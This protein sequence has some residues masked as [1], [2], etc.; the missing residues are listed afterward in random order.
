[1]D[2]HRRY[3]VKRVRPIPKAVL[4][5]IARLEHKGRTRRQAAGDPTVR[6]KGYVNA[7][8]SPHIN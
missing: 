6:L 5:I 7:T 4:Q 8:L 1:M 2:S 3:L